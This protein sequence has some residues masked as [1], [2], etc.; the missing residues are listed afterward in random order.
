V[1]IAAVGGIVGLNLLSQYV[2]WQGFP[3]QTLDVLTMLGFVILIGTAVNNPIL[4]VDQSLFHMRHEGYAPREAILEATSNR[5][6]PIFMT[7]TTTV[8]GLIPLVLMPGAGSELY[9]GLGAVVLG[10]LIASTLVSLVLV[11]VMFK[12]T[13]DIR[14]ALMG[15]LYRESAADASE[16]IAAPGH[17]AETVIDQ[18][19]S[20]NGQPLV[21]GQPLH[22]GQTKHAL[23]E[24]Y[25][26]RLPK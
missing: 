18:A 5:I 4:I 20:T 23:D 9:R 2:Q 1:P 6:R 15:W 10:G 17:D 7:T 25:S 14:G 19:S 11:P 26:A 12:L 8:F 13:Y 16:S 3:P 24:P 22:H 21:D